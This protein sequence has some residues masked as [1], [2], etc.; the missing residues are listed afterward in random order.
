M[1]HR[2]SETICIVVSERICEID[3]VGQSVHTERGTLVW[4]DALFQ[5]RYFGMDCAFRDEQCDEL[6]TGP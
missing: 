2:V 1:V 3:H 4:I 5:A 6:K